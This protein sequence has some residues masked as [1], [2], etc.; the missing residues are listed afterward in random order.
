M[1]RNAQPAALIAGGHFHSLGAARNLAK[2]G[3]PVY[4]VDSGP[5][6]CQY[7][8]YVKRVFKL[9]STDQENELV[10]ALMDLAGREEL[11]GSVLFPS[12]DESVRIFAQQRERLSARYRV[13]TPP[14]EVTSL[15]YDKRLTHG[16]ATRQGVPI[17]DTYNPRTE[18]ALAAMEYD[19]P[20]VLK[21]AITPH[22]TTVTKKKGYRAD[23]REEALERF[24]MMSALMDPAEILV[25]ELIPG[26]AE[27]LYSYVGLFRD[28]RPLAGLA[29]RR[30]RQHPMEFGRASTYVQTVDAPALE[31]LATRLMHGTGYS[32]LAEI[33]FMY[34]RKHERFEFLEVNPRIWGWH[35]VAARAGLHLPYLA[36]ADML[37]LPVIPSAPR[38]GTRWVRLVTDIPTAFSEIRAGRLSLRSY[39]ASLTGDLEDAVFTWSDPLAFVADVLLVP[40]YARKRGL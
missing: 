17:P 4:V 8:R 18:E 20:V 16:L 2:H 31:E 27:S 19:L 10:D 15:F 3:V 25:Q 5:C 40:Y 30:L 37:G 11:T 24:R 9:P 6:V 34:D 35:S 33:E 12:D 28:G 1:N 39:L 14:W 21:P 32:G 38:I 23:T 7:S 29:A 36:Y 13:T 22:L 26:R